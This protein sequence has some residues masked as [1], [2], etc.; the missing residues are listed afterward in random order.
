MDLDGVKIWYFPSRRLRRLYWSPLMAKALAEQ[1]GQFD[2]CHMHSVFLWP[3]WAAA[4]A[5]RRAGIPYVLSPR[6]MLV[7]ELIRRKSRWLK[8]AW[9]SLIERRNLRSAA[10]IHVTSGREHQDLEDLHLALGRVE[11]IPNGID[12]D[13]PSAVSALDP[14]LESALA[15][16]PCALYLGRLSWKKGIDR[17]LRVWRD[18]EVG[19]LVIAGNDDENLAPRLREMIAQWG[20]EPRVTLVARRIDAAEKQALFSRA[21]VMVLPSYSENFGNVVLEAMAAGCPVIVTP[22]VGAAEVVQAS[23]GGLISDENSLAAALDKLLRDADAAGDFGRRGQLFVRER[24]G[25]P[26]I[27]ARMSHL[28]RDVVG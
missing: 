25:W 21:R 17:L 7:R 4:R 13:Q 9:V 8:T 26:E 1:I 2:C 22:E 20:L 10:A 23:R 6:G 16:G 11:V 28:Y 5:A 19:H 24:F 3:T 15:S 12:L 18:V 27:A 14:A